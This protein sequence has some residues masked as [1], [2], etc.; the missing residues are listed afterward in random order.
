MSS[1]IKDLVYS[2]I[3]DVANGKHV[4]GGWQ[5]IKETAYSSCLEREELAS[6]LGSAL[7][8]LDG[9]Y[10]K[11]RNT[12]Q[13]LDNVFA[14]INK[15]LQELYQAY[16]EQDWR[17]VGDVIEQLKDVSKIKDLSSDN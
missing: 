16:V 17:R 10:E 12:R 5:A 4:P 1:P 14:R 9:N 11:H 3:H 7:Y 6:L 13:L 2:L 8:F 15:V